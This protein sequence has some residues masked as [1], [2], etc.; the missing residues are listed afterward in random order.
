MDERTRR[1]VARA[2]VGV[3]AAYV[4]PRVLGKRPG[5]AGVLVVAV[6]HHLFD[7]MVARWLA[8]AIRPA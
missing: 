7:E 4:V 8:Q 3:L 6:A 2:A 1:V 5:L